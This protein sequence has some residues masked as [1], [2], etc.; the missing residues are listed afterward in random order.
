LD[1]QDDFYDIYGESTKK[2]ALPEIIHVFTKRDRMGYEG[3]KRQVE[4]IE[5]LKN[6]GIIDKYFFVSPVS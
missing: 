1:E 6:E 5:G 2:Q 3:F 4:V